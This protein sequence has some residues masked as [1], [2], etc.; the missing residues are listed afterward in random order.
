MENFFSELL[1]NLSV[2]EGNTS[3]SAESSRRSSDVSG[4]KTEIDLQRQISDSSGYLSAS[5]SLNSSRRSFEQEDNEV[6]PRLPL[7][8]TT[9]QRPETPS[10]TDFLIAGAAIGAIGLTAYFGGKALISAVAQPA[11]SPSECEQVLKEIEK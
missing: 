2:D 6:P 3:D 1:R 7:R 11:S 5:S 10:F 4:R 9:P 8:G